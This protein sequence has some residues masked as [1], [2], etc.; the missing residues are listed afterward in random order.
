MHEGIV[1][2]GNEICSTKHIS[3]L[4]RLRSGSLSLEHPSLHIEVVRLLIQHQSLSI[5]CLDRPALSIKQS[6]TFCLCQNMCT[7][8]VS[9]FMILRSRKALSKNT[10]SASIWF[11]W[12]TDFHYLGFILD[13]T[14]IRQGHRIDYAQEIW[15][16]ECYLPD[17][18]NFDVK[19]AL[20]LRNALIVQ[21]NQIH[22]LQ[23]M[24]LTC[25]LQNCLIS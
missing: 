5:Q 20:F 7:L 22:R 6:L 9:E 24:Q 2:E 3:F 18:W 8:N 25:C 15:W 12:F 16:T 23:V 1:A 4:F 21:P 10:I 14:P 11:P 17:R 13:E 19:S